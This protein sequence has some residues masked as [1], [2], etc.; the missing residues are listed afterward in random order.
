MQHLHGSTSTKLALLEQHAAILP[1]SLMAVWL[2][3]LAARIASVLAAISGIRDSGFCSSSCTRRCMTPASRSARKCF[4][5]P[6]KLP[7]IATA[8]SITLCIAIESVEETS[9]FKYTTLHAVKKRVNHGQYCSLDKSVL[10]QRRAHDWEGGRTGSPSGLMCFM[11]VDRL[12][13]IWKIASLFASLP[14]VRIRR[15]SMALLTSCLSS[16]RGATLHLVSRS[17]T[18]Q[19]WDRVACLAETTYPCCTS[20]CMRPTF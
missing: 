17:W 12:E 2:A 15:Q 9:L 8:L 16:C 6:D 19:L 14:V 13:G 10:A 3:S 5:S 1:A 7:M 20:A 4:S 18:G 11:S